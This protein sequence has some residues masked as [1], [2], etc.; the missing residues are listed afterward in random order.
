MR[1]DAIATH[2]EDVSLE[3]VQRRMAATQP[4]NATK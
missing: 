2:G 4:D 3:E 1:F